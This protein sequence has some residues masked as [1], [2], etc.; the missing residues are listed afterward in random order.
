MREI[1]IVDDTA[2]NLYLLQSILVAEGYQVRVATNGKM[3][4]QSVQIS[5]P[6]LILMDI[7][8]PEMN[9]FEACQK[10]KKQTQLCDI[11]VIFIS[12]YAEVEQISEAFSV[13]GCDY[14]C[15]PFNQNE[16]LIRVKNQF[17]LLDA[18][19]RQIRIKMLSTIMNLTVGIAHEINTP[20]GISITSNSYLEYEIQ[21]FKAKVQDQSISRSDIEDFISNC[22]SS[23]KLAST[24][25]Y[26]VSQLIESFRMLLQDQNSPNSSF[27]LKQQ[28]DSIS[29]IHSEA[30]IETK[31][32]VVVSGDNIQLYT[33]QDTITNLFNNLILNS[34]QHA[35]P[36]GG[37]NSIEILLK[38]E[39]KE[40]YIRYRD[41]G[42]GMKDESLQQLFNPFW[43]EK[44]SGS[45]IGLS[46]TLIFNSVTLGLH[47]KISATSS[48]KHGLC[49]EIRFPLQQHTQH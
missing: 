18:Q 33:S 7:N 30:L 9:G 35:Y 16:V 6:E 44:R 23:S 20:L 49:Y 14:I 40:V 4:L 48:K 42:I 46:A 10:I 32:N 2:E 21:N 8:M 45:H 11:P 39:K 29:T 1:L 31:T 41:N 12:A 34:L 15:K 17:T 36:D 26:K 25:L 19:E 37:S 22:E 3:A 43:L 24:N 27:E 38:Q 13:G 28:I 47:G 5:Q